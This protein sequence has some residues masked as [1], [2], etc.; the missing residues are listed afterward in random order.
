MAPLD[1]WEN[2]LIGSSIGQEG[3]WGVSVNQGDANEGSILTL[4]RNSQGEVGFFY[5]QGTQ[6]PPYRAY[7]TYNNIQDPAA[8]FM[9]RIDDNEESGIEEID[10]QQI[11]NSKSENRKYYDLQGRRVNGKP[12][13]GIYIREGKKIMIK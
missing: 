8:R 4:G 13:R 2:K 7:L 12:A 6:I 10:N 5:Y 1:K 3:K 9:L 11:V